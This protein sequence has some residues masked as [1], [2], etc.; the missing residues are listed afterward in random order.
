ML[1]RPWPHLCILYHTWRSGSE[2]GVW[3]ALAETLP[4]PRVLPQCLITQIPIKH[5][6]PHFPTLSCEDEYIQSVQSTEL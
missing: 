4:L 5:F 3:L 1:D 6:L 2:G